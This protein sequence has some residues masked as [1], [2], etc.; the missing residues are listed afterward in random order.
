MMLPFILAVAMQAAPAPQVQV[1]SR[2]MMSQ[3]E[4]ARQSVA[5][6]AAEFAALWKL[7]AGSAPAPAVDFRTRM[8]VAVFLGTRTSAG[9]SADIVGT[10]HAGGK[11]IVE[12]R[13]RKPARDEVAAQII[14]SPAIIATIPAFAG[15]VTFE[16]VEP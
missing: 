7:H 11:L 6:S 13:E 8:V 5:R 3:V 1:L 2:D 9:F 4:D 10:R 12:W 15:E 16:Q 14:T